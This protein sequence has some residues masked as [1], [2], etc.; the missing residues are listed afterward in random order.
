MDTKQIY[1]SYLVLL[2]YYTFM[3]GL[4]VREKKNIV[5]VRTDGLLKLRLQNLLQLAGYSV[6]MIFFY[7]TNLLR[8]CLMQNPEGSNCA[9]GYTLNAPKEQVK[10]VA[11]HEKVQL[12]TR[13]S[14]SSSEG[15]QPFT[16]ILFGPL[17]IFF[18]SKQKQEQNKLGLIQI[19]HHM[20]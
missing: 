7:P 1:L 2:L 9:L 5:G 13:P 3:N 4:P 10:R 14:F 6:R 8:F 12:P 15:L 16:K 17:D 11:W 19:I 20:L 18:Y